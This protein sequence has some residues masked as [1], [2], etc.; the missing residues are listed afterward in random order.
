MIQF[1]LDDLIKLASIGADAIDDWHHDTVCLVQESR[2][3]MYGCDLR[4]AT[5][6]GQTLG[7]LESLL[8]LDRHF[9]ERN[10]HGFGL[11]SCI[12]INGT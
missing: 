11:S 3:Q 10:R 4:I 8:C 6:T 9:I 5:I 12:S 7:A 1:G 2:Q